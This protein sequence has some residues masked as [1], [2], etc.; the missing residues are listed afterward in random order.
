MTLEQRQWQNLLDLQARLSDY[1]R[2]ITE[3]PELG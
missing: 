3:P 2:R 1:M